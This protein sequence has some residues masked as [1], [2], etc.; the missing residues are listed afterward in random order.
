MSPDL[1]TL[2]AVSTSI[3]ACSVVLVP[4]AL[5]DGVAATLIWL[6]EAAAATAAVAL[7]NCRRVVPEAELGSV[8]QFRHAWLN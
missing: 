8:F 2:V 1:A 6:T 3:S 7:T 5:R 4:V